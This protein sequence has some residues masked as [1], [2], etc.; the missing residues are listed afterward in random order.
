MQVWL[1]MLYLRKEVVESLQKLLSF[2]AKLDEFETN[3]VI[4]PTI[5][6]LRIDR[7]ANPYDSA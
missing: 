3:L 4:L 5:Y 6:N 7:L 2:R 1:F